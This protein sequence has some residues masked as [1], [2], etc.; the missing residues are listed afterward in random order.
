MPNLIQTVMNALPPDAMSAISGLVGE[1]PGATT[2]GVTAAIPALLAGALQKSSTPSGANDLVGLLRQVTSG[3]NPI[4]NVGAILTDPNARSALLSQGQGVANSLLGG[5]TDAVGR[6]IGSAQGMGGT[7]AT[8]ILA[9][10]APLVMGAIGRVLGGSPTVSG[11]QSLL[12]GERSSIMSALPPGLG[13]LFNLGAPAAAVAAP[14][15]A[16]AGSRSWVWIAAIV[17]LALLGFLGLRYCSSQNTM[18]GH[19]SL[20]LPGGGTIDV[21]EGSIGYGV[22]KFLDSSDPAP[23]TFV[24]DNLNFATGSDTLTPESAATVNTLIAILKAYPNVHARIVGY[25]DNQGDPAA[26][27]KL[28]EAR[29]VTVKQQIVNGGIAADRLAT[30]GM[31]EDKPIADN[32]TDEGR[33]KNRRT[34]LEIT[35]K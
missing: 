22:A 2:A 14:A 29:A 19:V 26:N 16:A 12:A 18:P 17:A 32:G 33:A 20:S 13:S 28:S 9:M 24:F 11:L 35:S 27:Q 4:D 10:L 25:T 23:K 5:S 7:A 31:G 1:S 21:A 15:V 30:A 8:G 34:E 3:G 6:L